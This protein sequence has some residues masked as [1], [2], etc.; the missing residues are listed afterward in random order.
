LYY[1]AQIGQW[2]YNVRPDPVSLFYLPGKKV[3]TATLIN[4][5]LDFIKIRDLR[6]LDDRISVEVTR[7]EASKGERIEMMVTPKEELPTGT[8]LTN[9]EVVLDVPE[10]L[11]AF[12]VT[13]PVKI[14]RY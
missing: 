9:F 7:D 8:Y 10:G 14:V 11:E 3:K 2:R 12:V 5:E 6:I 4:N 1:R 13:I